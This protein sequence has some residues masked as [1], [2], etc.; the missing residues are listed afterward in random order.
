MG[1]TAEKAYF[2]LHV[3]VVID[4]PQSFCGYG[5]TQAV[6]LRGLLSRQLITLPATCAKNLSQNRKGLRALDT[7]AGR[8]SVGFPFDT[9]PG[10][11]GERGQVTVRRGA[12]R[13]CDFPQDREVPLAGSGTGEFHGE[14]PFKEIRQCSLFSH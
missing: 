13:Q 4:Q 5:A 8:P 10:I 12:H 9:L 6:S 2:Q 3:P 7:L 14:I 11:I 1:S